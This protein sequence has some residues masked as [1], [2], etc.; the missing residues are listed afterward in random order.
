MWRLNSNTVYY[1]SPVF[2]GFKVG[3]QYSMTG[4]ADPDVQEDS[5][6][7]ENNNFGNVAL[8]WDGANGISTARKNRASVMTLGA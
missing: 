5:R 3:A 4:A 1:V 6:W 2:A 8:R 7:S